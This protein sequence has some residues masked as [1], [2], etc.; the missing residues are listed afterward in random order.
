MSK[1]KGKLPKEVIEMIENKITYGK[2]KIEAAKYIEHYWNKLV[3]DG[4]SSGS[5]SV[6]RCKECE[7]T[8]IADPD[9]DELPAD[10]QFLACG[11]GR[12]ETT[13]PKDCAVAR[14]WIAT[15][16]KMCPSARC[17]WCNM[18]KTAHGIPGRTRGIAGA[19]EKFQT[20]ARV[21]RA[22]Q[23]PP[24][25]I[26]DRG[27]YDTIIQTYNITMPVTMPRWT[28]EDV[29]VEGDDDPTR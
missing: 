17:A 1:Q 15:H 24:E 12:T 7:A 8:N 10:E 21:P 14:E 11:C 28:W 26:H 5:Y 13:V 27:I 16:R 22:P 2:K 18:N 3:L 20:A 9:D 6:W 4:G 25:R 29:V 23:A 19:C